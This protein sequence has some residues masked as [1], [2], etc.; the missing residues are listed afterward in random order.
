MR[1][2]LYGN[3][4]LGSEDVKI[5]GNVVKPDVPGYRGDWGIGA[6]TKD[7]DVQR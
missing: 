1:Y 7:I 2:P 3:F 5:K 6:W 4:I